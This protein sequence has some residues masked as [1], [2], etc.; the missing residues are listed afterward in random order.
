M[1][2]LVNNRLWMHVF[3]NDFF[4]GD[5]LPQRYA[6]WVNIALFWDNFAR[7]MLRCLKKTIQSMILTF[8]RLLRWLFPHLV[9]WSS[10]YVL[11]FWAAF[12]GNSLR[13]SEIS[14]F[15]DSAASLLIFDHKDVGRLDIKVNNPLLVTVLQSFRQLNWSSEIEN[16]RLSNVVTT[17]YM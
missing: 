1:F 14:Q 16:A 7:Q 4:L 10:N 2:Y 8:G 9:S 3:V 15:E 13:A 12:A 6:K 5:Q 17:N 11:C